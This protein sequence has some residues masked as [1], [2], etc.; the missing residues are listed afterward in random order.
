MV[1]RTVVFV[2]YLN[3]CRTARET[4][5]EGA[6]RDPIEQI[7]PLL[8]A[9]TLVGKGHPGTE[10]TEARVYRAVPDGRRDP[11]GFSAALRQM[12]KW[13]EMGCVVVQRPMRYAEADKGE[14]HGDS[15]SLAVVLAIDITLMA[16]R[17]QYD[18]AIVCSRD[19]DLVP[20]LKAVLDQTT[21]T[22]TWYSKNTPWP[23]SPRPTPNRAATNRP[24][25]DRSVNMQN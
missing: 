13:G 3:V 22:P 17:D 18:I 16:W 14:G 8:L 9:Q 12:T 5:R 4:F 7:Q 20:D 24:T 10:L 25:P 19:M 15:K 6:S 1:T 21:S 11:E 23:A 2:D